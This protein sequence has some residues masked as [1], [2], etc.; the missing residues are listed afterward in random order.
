[1]SETQKDIVQYLICW[2]AII[3]Y[4]VVQPNIVTGVLL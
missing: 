3:G 1:M 2:V 4:M